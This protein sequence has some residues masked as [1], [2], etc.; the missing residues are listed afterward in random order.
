MGIGSGGIYSWRL[1]GDAAYELLYS[2]VGAV[3]NG[4]FVMD[5]PKSACPVSP[6]LAA[7]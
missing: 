4:V 5:A 7:E 3:L 1:R 2:T 6:N